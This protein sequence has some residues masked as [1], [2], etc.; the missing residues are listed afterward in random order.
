L[1]TFNQWLSERKKKQADKLI[2]NGALSSK[3]LQNS[4]MLPLV[5]RSDMPDARG[6]ASTGGD[7]KNKKMATNLYV[8]NN[9]KKE[10]T[11]GISHLQVQR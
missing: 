8:T 1:P 4:G 7:M 5:M 3:L 9:S 11:P 6:K 10:N 2:H